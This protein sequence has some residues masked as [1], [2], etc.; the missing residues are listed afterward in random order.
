MTVHRVALTN[1]FDDRGNRFENVTVRV[2]TI[3]AKADTISDNPICATY[4]GPSFMATSVI[5]TCEEPLTGTFV[6]VQQV[7]ND[8]KKILSIREVYICGE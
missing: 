6:L 4:L 5:M 8:K 2:G 3:S 1:R 7:H